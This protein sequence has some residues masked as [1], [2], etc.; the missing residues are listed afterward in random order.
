MA[1]SEFGRIDGKPVQEVRLRGA[2]GTEAAVLTYGAIL[3]DL[4]VPVGTTQTRRVV[5]GYR[6]LAGY[7]EGRAYVGATVGRCINRIDRGFTLD[8]RR[9][10]LPVNEGSRVQLHGGPAGFSKRVWR[11]VACTDHA[12]TLELVSPDGDEGYPGELT[13]RCTYAI[14]IPGTLAVE[15]TATTNAPT[16]ANLGH[17]SYF[18]LQSGSDVRDHRLMVAADFYTPLDKDLI[19]TG[20]IR[21]VADTVYDFRSLRSIG[22]QERPGY[23][24]NFVLNQGW[25]R[26][27][28]AQDLPVA[29][30]L[31]SPSGDLAMDLVTTEP[32]LQFY[33]GIRLPPSP[34]AYEGEPHG[35]YRG[36]C[37]EPQRFPDSI[38]RPHFSPVVLR[39]GERYRQVTTFR[40]S[41]P[42]A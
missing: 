27:G 11:L 33:E 16:V 30:R 39:P 4:V 19:P 9:Y 17:H 38:N 22:R 23:D 34:D 14:E 24:I 42:A 7:L 41:Q 8:G 35:P 1:I 32:G 26:D 20:E 5:L 10:E 18:T 29:A 36:L 31:V 2:G 3:R 15:L 40:F 12:A 28:N 21:R 37:L 6:S 13:A 25:L